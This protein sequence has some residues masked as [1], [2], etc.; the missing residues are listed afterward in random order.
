MHAATQNPQA[1][2]DDFAAFE[3]SHGCRRFHWRVRKVRHVILSFVSLAASGEL[4][5]YVGRNSWQ[6]ERAL[7]AD[8]GRTW[9]LAPLEA[10]LAEIF[11]D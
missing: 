2:Q 6:L 7:S 9:R 5:V 11:G 3:L 4:G 8:V 1:V 10:N